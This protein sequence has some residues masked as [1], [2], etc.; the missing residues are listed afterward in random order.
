MER[1]EEIARMILAQGDAV[2][3]RRIGF[4]WHVEGLRGPR[5]QFEH[6]HEAVNRA[7][8]E[9]NEREDISLTIMPDFG[10]RTASPLKSFSE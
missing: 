8:E 4:G 1:Q 7:L 2:V 6:R 10:Y 5:E 3:V 9:F